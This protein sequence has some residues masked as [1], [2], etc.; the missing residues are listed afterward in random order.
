MI[1]K[2]TILALLSILLLQL[3]CNSA[4][5]EFQEAKDLGSI[6]SMIQF[7]NDH[8]NSELVD[9]A[10]LYLTKYKFQEA[11]DLNSVESMIQFITDYPN[12]ELA[13]SAKLYLTKYKEELIHNE[14]CYITT[15]THIDEYNR[16]ADIVIKNIS[17][18]DIA[19]VS[20]KYNNFQ[21]VA[22]HII[23]ISIADTI[24]TIH[25]DVYE[26]PENEDILCLDY[27]GNILRRDGKAVIVENVSAN[28]KSVSEY[29][30]Q[31]YHVAGITTKIYPCL[32]CSDILNIPEC[33]FVW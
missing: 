18:E 16:I 14:T 2:K 26:N 23:D 6:E 12:S 4:H 22:A 25:Y 10:N 7:I 15:V 1:S 30:Y 11:K 5:K 8:P 20:F 21:R 13:D 32:N 29:Q 27:N 3:S 31:G 24:H 19:R 33:F 17:E 28:Q 9:S